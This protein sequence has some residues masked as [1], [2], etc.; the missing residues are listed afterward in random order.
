[1]LKNGK[2]PLTTAKFSAELN[3]YSF[4]LPALELISNHLKNQ[5]QRIKIINYLARGNI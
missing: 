5:M 1:M 2:V 4:N 3:A